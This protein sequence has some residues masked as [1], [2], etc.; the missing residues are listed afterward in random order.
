MGST[1]GFFQDT[2]SDIY[3]QTGPMHANK[4]MQVSV[5]RIELTV[6]FIFVWMYISNLCECLFERRNSKLRPLNSIFHLSFAYLSECL[7]DICRN[8]C[9]ITIWN[10]F[11]ICLNIHFIW[12]FFLEK[13]LKIAASSFDILSPKNRPELS[14]SCTAVENVPIHKYYKN[15]KKIVN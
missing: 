11:F 7:L 10:L 13:E 14:E 12:M 5:K 1:T 9:L 6:N 15:I 8:V 3:H 2:E 4:D